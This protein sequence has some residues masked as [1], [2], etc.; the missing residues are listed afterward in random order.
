MSDVSD[1]ENK[2]YNGVTRVWLF[3]RVP[4]GSEC[5]GLQCCRPVDQLKRKTPESLKKSKKNWHTYTG[6]KTQLPKQ[7]NQYTFQIQGILTEVEGS[8]QLTSSLRKFVLL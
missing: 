1:E 6:A 7:A 3:C 8:V 2:V 4:P 5:T